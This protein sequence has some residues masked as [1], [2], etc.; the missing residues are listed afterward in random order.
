MP[1]SILLFS[2][3]FIFFHWFINKIWTLLLRPISKKIWCIIFY[4]LYEVHRTGKIYSLIKSWF[5]LGNVERYAVSVIWELH[6][7]TFKVKQVS[8]YTYFFL[9]FRFRIRALLWIQPKIEKSL[10]S[11]FFLNNILTRLIV[12][13]YVCYF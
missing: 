7:K 2:V 5:P 11:T 1:F 4:Y 10:L 3:Y 12:A 9:R 13:F 6:P 8:H